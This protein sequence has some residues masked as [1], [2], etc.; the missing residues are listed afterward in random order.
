MNFALKIEIER[1]VNTPVGN[2]GFSAIPT[3]G[4][5]R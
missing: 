3:L 2:K 4:L 5:I 1:D